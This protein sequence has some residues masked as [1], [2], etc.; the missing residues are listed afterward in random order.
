MHVHARDFQ[1]AKRR[2]DIE[3]RI[4]P[5]EKV[6]VFVQV[7]V[8][9][10]AERKRYVEQCALDYIIDLPV[11]HDVGSAENVGRI[12]MAFMVGTPVEG[13]VRGR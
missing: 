2:G 4:Y 3:K 5:K 8:Y 13:D 7:S 9:A 6:T 11:S 12:H 1:V 10:E